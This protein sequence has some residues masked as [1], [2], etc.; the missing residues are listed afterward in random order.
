MGFLFNLDED[1]SE[2]EHSYILKSAIVV[3]DVFISAGIPFDL[4]NTN[5]VEEIISEKVEIYDELTKNEETNTL[6]SW[7][8]KSDSPVLFETVLSHNP[9]KADLEQN[10]ALVIDILIGFFEEATADTSKDKG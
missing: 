2:A 1:F 9:V 8:E 4:V 10:M 5:K 6:T 7:I 3:R